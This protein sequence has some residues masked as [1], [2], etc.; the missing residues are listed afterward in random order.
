M[1][2]DVTAGY[3]VWDVERLRAPIEKIN[4]YILK[5]AGAIE[6]APVVSLE[7]KRKKTI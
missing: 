7:N 3:I 1:G 6:T 4:E 2:G 5:Q